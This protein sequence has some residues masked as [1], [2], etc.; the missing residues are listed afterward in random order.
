MP[1]ISNPPTL[2][3]T[4][5]ASFGSGS[6]MSMPFW[7]TS[8]FLAK[9]L[10]SMPVPR[11]VM[12][13]T[14]WPVTAAPMALEGE[15]LPIPMSPVP[16]KS[17]P[18][19]NRSAANSQPA[20]TDRSACSLVIAG[21]IV[22]SL[23]PFAIF[24]TISRSSPCNSVAPADISAVKSET[25]AMMPVSTTRTRTAAWRAKTLIPAPPRTKVLTISPVTS[26]G[27]ALTP[28]AATP[29]SPAMT[30]TALF[31]TEGSRVRLMPQIR[32]AITCS[33]P[34]ARSGMTSLDVCSR[35]RRVTS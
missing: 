23:V 15:V 16:S 19:S 29:W 12:R 21:P 7:M 5:S 33:S 10:L 27:Q 4:S 24:L 22:K 1:P 8:H 3:N 35:A 34:R 30:S 14:G 9:P 6:L 18:C 28:F 20:I 2:L 26:W 13:S 32:S 31:F 17:A 25:S 11:P